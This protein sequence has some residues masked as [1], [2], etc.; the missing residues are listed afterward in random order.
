MNRGAQPFR[1]NPVSDFGIWVSE[2]AA[3]SAGA[4]TIAAGRPTGPATHPNRSAARTLFALG[5]RRRAV[6]SK[7]EAGNAKRRKPCERVFGSSAWRW[8][9]RRLHPRRT[10]PG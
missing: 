7:L 6:T 1:H 9:F 3:R 4:H 2:T 5:T 10:Y 8:S